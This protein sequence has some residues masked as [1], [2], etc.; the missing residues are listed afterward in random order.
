[1]EWSRKA[2]QLCWNM[3]GSEG[4][5]EAHTVSKVCLFPQVSPSIRIHL[6]LNLT[7]SLQ[8]AACLVCSIF[9]FLTSASSFL[10]TVFITKPV[11]TL[12]ATIPHQIQSSSVHAQAGRRASRLGAQMVLWRV[13]HLWV[14]EPAGRQDGPSVADMAEAIPGTC[15]WLW[16]SRNTA[17][18][19]FRENTAST[20]QTEGLTAEELDNTL[21]CDSVNDYCKAARQWPLE[22]VRSAKKR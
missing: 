18:L 22:G 17:R 13:S 2:L 4:M 8:T 15:L 7:A 9:L 10:I 11:R 12:P 1:M 21:T 5:V 3:F 16:T 6:Y 19:A 14:S 20:Q